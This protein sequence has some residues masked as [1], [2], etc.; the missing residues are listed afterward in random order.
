MDQKVLLKMA[1]DI[2]EIKGTVSSIKS[3]QDD[4]IENTEKIFSS[5]GRKIRS[6][7]DDRVKVLSVGAFIAAFVSTMGAWFFGKS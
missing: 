7:E 4:H 6:L 5:H 2:G 1:N 3:A